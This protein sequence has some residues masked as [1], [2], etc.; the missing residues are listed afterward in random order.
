MGQALQLLTPSTPT[1]PLVIQQG[2]GHS[3]HQGTGKVLG[4]NM[5]GGFLQARSAILR[6][7]FMLTLAEDE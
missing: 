3:H 1:W 2:R 5:E 4:S 7:E 6:G